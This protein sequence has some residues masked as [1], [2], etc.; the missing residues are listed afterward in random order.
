M[1]VDLIKFPMWDNGYRFRLT[2]ID[3]YN[4]FKWL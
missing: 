1:V 3:L 2:A 4:K